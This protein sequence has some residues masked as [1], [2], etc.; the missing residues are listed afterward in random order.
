MTFWP[1]QDMNMMTKAERINLFLAGDDGFF[2]PYL[3]TLTS[4]LKSTPNTCFHV[5]YAGKISEENRDR[6]RS[7][8]ARIEVEF[9]DCLFDKWR[10]YIQTIANP[11]H[12]Q[13]ECFFR[14]FA[15]FELNVS[16]MIWLDGDVIVNINLW[17]LFE[18]DLSGFS[19]G[20]A[21]SDMS[22]GIL[23][24]Y[25]NAGVVLF[26]CDAIRNKHSLSDLCGCIEQHKLSVYNF[27]EEILNYFFLTD[28]KVLTERYNLIVSD[29]LF[30]KKRNLNEAIIHF[31][32]HKPWKVCYFNFPAK[33][34]FWR[35]GKRIFGIDRYC[36]VSCASICV[37]PFF[38]VRA[39]C[40]R[41]GAF[42]RNRV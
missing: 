40:Y 35:Y 17:T 15:P 42:G 27:D 23:N 41:V 32:G 38:V 39:A 31:W 13:A 10:P 4:V 1:F 2:L 5:F 28:K 14:V 33:R 8:S 26:D 9:V 7:F 25:F 21:K 16:R 19:V 6:L 29:K 34:F 11:G 18:E 22:Y 3:V 12:H 24:P 30:A 37:F 20:V 36:F